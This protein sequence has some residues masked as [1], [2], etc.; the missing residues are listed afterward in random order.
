MQ[1]FDP[2]GPT[3]TSTLRCFLSFPRRHWAQFSTFSV[4]V[5]CFTSIASDSLYPSSSR[6]FCVSVLTKH[7]GWVGV[8]LLLYT[9]LRRNK[10]IILA[11]WTRSTVLVSQCPSLLCRSRHCTACCNSLTLPA[12]GVTVFKMNRTLPC[13][14]L[15]TVRS[16]CVHSLSTHGCWLLGTMLSHQTGDSGESSSLL[17]SSTA[18]SLDG[19]CLLNL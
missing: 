9:T 17:S 4:I 19:R 12:V 3:V 16:S 18:L 2:A 8:S 10:D 6:Q 5:H 1:Q 15:V 13:Q 14:P 11:Y 7:R